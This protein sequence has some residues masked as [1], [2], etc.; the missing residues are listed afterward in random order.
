[1]LE[2]KVELKVTLTAH[3]ED[4]K[5]LLKKAYADGIVFEELLEIFIGDL[6]GGR[7][8]SGSDESRL[9]DEWYERHVFPRT[10]RMSFVQY[11]IE[12]G[13]ID[14]CVVGEFIRNID[15]CESAYRQRKKKED[16]ECVED[17]I[18]FILDEM[19]EILDLYEEYRASCKDCEELRQALEEACEFA[20]M[21]RRLRGLAWEMVEFTQEFWDRL[22]GYIR[23]CRE[24]G[25][26]HDGVISGSAY[27]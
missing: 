25:V 26:P 2:R 21:E 4:F 3:S 15:L 11:L 6:A 20:M 8:A 23:T 14:P 22:D 27:G 10:E 24:M 12:R 13:N 1:M 18:G 17:Y 7:A 5:R 9:A 19:K 16:G